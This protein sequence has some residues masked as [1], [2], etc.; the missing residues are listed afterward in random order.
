MSFSVKASESGKPKNFK[1]NEKS[2]Q[3]I[4]LSSGLCCW[5]AF[6]EMFGFWGSVL[7]PSQLRNRQPKNAWKKTKDHLILLDVAWVDV[8]FMYGGIVLFLN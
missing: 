1:E 7:S 2:P 8:P 5:L 4:F 6:S 3:E